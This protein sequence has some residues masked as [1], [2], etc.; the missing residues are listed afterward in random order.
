MSIRISLGALACAFTIC[1]TSFALAADP[2]DSPEV[3]A[4]ADVLQ[5]LKEG[6][7]RFVAGDLHHPHDDMRRIKETAGGQHPMATIITCSDSRLPAEI[8]FDQGIGDLFIIRVAGNVSDTDEIGTAEY[9]THHLHTP[10]VVVMGHTKCGAVAA[11]CTH[12]EVSGSIPGL[13]DNIVPAVERAREATGLEGEALVPAAVQENVWQS[14][15][16]LISHSATVA[17]LVAGGHVMVVGAVYDI[18]TGQVEWLGGHPDEDAL[19]AAAGEAH[20]A[21]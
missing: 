16:D 19:V 4:A 5:Q 20:A 8:I 18:A 14:I 6:N 17:E 3:P 21:H 7:A 10:L 11:V 1:N 2:H 13:V 12:A 9:G 15:S